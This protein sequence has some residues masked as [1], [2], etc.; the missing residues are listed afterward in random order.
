MGVVGCHVVEEFR[1]CR[2]AAELVIGVVLEDGWRN[3]WRRGVNW[4]FCWFLD[5]LRRVGGSARVVI[6]LNRRS[7]RWRGGD[8]VVIGWRLGGVGWCSVGDGHMDQSGGLVSCGG[9]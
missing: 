7:S 4:H 3:V 1:K 5:F 6:H 9:V 2:W 8:G